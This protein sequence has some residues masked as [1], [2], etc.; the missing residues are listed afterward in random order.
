V[1]LVED[2]Q[3]QALQF[4][5]LLKKEGFD[6]TLAANG[7]LGL[8]AIEESPPEIVL[9]DLQMPE[10]DGLELV[11]RV[12]K[13]WP[14]LPV[15][16]MT[17]HG[18]EEIAAEALRSGAASY[19]PKHTAR[20]DIA[21]TVRDVLEV[22]Q[23]QREQHRLREYLTAAESDFLLNND[24][25]LIRPLIARIESDVHHLWG[26]DESNSI[27]MFVALREALENAVYHG[28]L[29]VSSELREDGGFEYYELANRRRQE[30]PFRERRVHV[31]VRI[32]REDA[33]F[34]VRDEGPGFDPASLPDPTDPA[35][36]EKASGRGLILIRTFMD[37]VRHNAS[38]NEITMTKRFAAR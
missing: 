29:E 12:Q 9:T 13:R 38:G 2:S 16:L 1:L 4:Q 26:G 37:D 18:S 27:R 24:T 11:K 8:K 3:T 6:V 21:A 14:L 30:P 10:M 33:V 31:R 36:L 28:N 23:P 22:V 7:A 15:I 19:F 32:S 34:T 20:Y 17:A 35:N 5:L 25:S